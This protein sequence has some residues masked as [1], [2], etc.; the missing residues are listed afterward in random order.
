MIKR[1]RNAVF[2]SGRKKATAKAHICSHVNRGLRLPPLRFLVSCCYSGFMMWVAPDNLGLEGECLLDLKSIRCC[3]QYRGSFRLFLCLPA[4]G[5]S[6]HFGGTAPHKCQHVQCTAYISSTVCCERGH[7]FFY[8]NKMFKTPLKQFP[9]CCWW[10]SLNTRVSP[11]GTVNFPVISAVLV[12]PKTPYSLI[13][14]TICF[15]ETKQI[16]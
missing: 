6:R 3:Q 5:F 11:Q 15:L 1:E 9:S 14:A 7:Y 12:V 13:C 8:K 16:L 2:S 4:A 10:N